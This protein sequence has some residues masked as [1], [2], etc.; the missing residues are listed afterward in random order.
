MY[1]FIFNSVL[2]LFLVIGCQN[3]N[4]SP[5]LSETPKETL[6]RINIENNL[7]MNPYVNITKS[8][9]TEC[10]LDTDGKEC[11]EGNITVSFDDFILSG[12]SGTNFPCEIQVTT[13][14]VICGS[15][16]GFE[17]HLVEHD[18]EIENVSCNGD[19]NTQQWECIK[20]RVRQLLH[21]YLIE[22]WMDLIF[23]SGDDVPCA[24]TSYYTA[25]KCTSYCPQYDKFGNMIRVNIVPCESSA[26]CIIKRPW[27]RENGDATPGD[28][29]TSQFGSCN[30][31]GGCQKPGKG[32]PFDTK[33]R[34]REVCA[35]NS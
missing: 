1:K 5:S 23:G 27:C 6:Q 8:M 29:E 28:I 22:G 33:C 32:V 13:D 2:V 11:L 34:L 24:F 15:S 4:D 26:C 16:A 17:L 25:M 19:W 7:K 3:M 9:N 31:E 12:C 21:D 35:I 10:E 30:P 18:M 14:Y 20:E